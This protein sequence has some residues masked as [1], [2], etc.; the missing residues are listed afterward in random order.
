MI[1]ITEKKSFFRILINK[2]DVVG[3]YSEPINFTFNIAYCRF[4]VP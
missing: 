2:S 4:A 1:E 3:H